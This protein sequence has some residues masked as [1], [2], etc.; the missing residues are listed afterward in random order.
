V[1]KHCSKGGVPF[2]S[3]G[4]LVRGFDYYTGVVWEVTAAGLGAQK[5]G[6]RRRRYDNLVETLGGRPTPGVGFGCG[7]ERFS[8]RSKRSRSPPAGRRSA[9]RLA[10]RARR[11]ARGLQLAPHARLRAAGVRCDW[12]SPAD[13]SRTSSSSRSVKKAAYTIVVGED[14]LK[15]NARVLTADEFSRRGNSHAVPRDQSHARDWT[16]SAT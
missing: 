5:R 6:R 1:R 8:S 14:E 11:R 10:R 15:S 7:L 3:I 4:T 12:T 16:V 13:P 9:A 2:A